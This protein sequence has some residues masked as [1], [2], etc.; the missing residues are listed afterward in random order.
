V[1]TLVVSF[2]VPITAEQRG[3]INTLVVLVITI[4]AGFL[5]RSQVTPV[6]AVVPPPH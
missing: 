3:A 1:L 5:V 2:G 4:G 6:A